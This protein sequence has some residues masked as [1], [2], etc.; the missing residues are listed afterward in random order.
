VL[1]L[2]LSSL[3]SGGVADAFVIKH[4]IGGFG[5]LN[6]LLLRA[7]GLSPAGPEASDPFEFSPGAIAVM[8]F[9][10]FAYL[11][12]YLNWFSK[13]KIIRWH[14]VSKAR[15]AGVL[16]LWAGAIAAYLIDYDLG[17]KLLFTLSAL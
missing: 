14:E 5:D 13:T 4:Y 11:Y 17:V 12:H 8:R 1:L 16:G 15:L 10:A 2:S 6:V 3:P 7:F 9:I